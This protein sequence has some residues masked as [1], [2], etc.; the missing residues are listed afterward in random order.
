MRIE[1]KADLIIRNSNFELLHSILDGAGVL[2]LPPPVRSRRVSEPVESLR[3]QLRER[4]Y[5]SHG[6]ER[7]F[8]RDPW[9]SRAFW[10]ELGVVAFKAAALVAAFASLAHT[11]VMLFRNG[12]LGASETLI[13]F[14]VYGAVWI[15]LAAALVIAIALA[16]K[17]RPE[18]PI[19]N[20]KVLLMI[21]IGAS[22]AIAAAFGLWWYAFDTPPSTIEIVA[23]VALA[24]L[25]FLV[26]TVVISAAILSF[27]IYEL[28]RI[29]AIHQKPRTIP[30]AAAAAVLIALLF[31]PAYATG[32][33]EEPAPLQVVTRPSVRRLALIAADGLTFELL[34]TRPALTRQFASLHAAGAIRGASAA[35]RWASL[36]TGVPA[37]LH[38]VRSIA[39]VRLAAS[40]TVLQSVSRA[41]WPLQRIAPTAGLARLEPLPPT[42]RRRD[43]AWEILAARGVPS[44]AVNWWTSGE[45]QGALTSIGQETIFAGARGDALRLDA[46]AERRFTAAVEQRRPQFATVYLPALDVLLNRLTSDR[47]VEVAGVMQALG[48]F[49]ATIAR[50]QNAG[51]DIVLAGMPGEGQSGQA[52]IAATFPI[53]KPSTTFDVA[54]TLLDFLGFPSSNEM[55]GHALAGTT[56]EPRISSYGPHAAPA[57]TI[58]LNQEFYESLRSLGYIR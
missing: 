52:V 53:A 28:K 31:I 42:V 57:G 32:R 2:H 35:E 46:L 9:S 43:F 10:S 8:A 27:S 45:Q 41:D 4:G 47:S 25:L 20:P 48:G 18:V 37:S 56:R 40:T 21:S 3:A 36:G 29:P 17:S 55:P 26:S 24:G 50:L 16:L 12:P 19:D 15:A 51:Y 58:K 14:S 6:I 44:V 1:S 23:G 33:R 54:P 11:A 22:G 13:L 38:G 7:W 30:I 39:G 34:R 5:L 49:E